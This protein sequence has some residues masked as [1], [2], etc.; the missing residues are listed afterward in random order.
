[1]PKDAFCAIKCTSCVSVPVPRRLLRVFFWSVLTPFLLTR[2]SQTAFTLELTEFKLRYSV[3]S[4]H[5]EHPALAGNTWGDENCSSHFPY[6]SMITPWRHLSHFKT[7][8]LKISLHP[9][10]SFVL[11]I[12]CEQKSLCTKTMDN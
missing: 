6:T 9:S 11:D 12:L 8:K 4:R 7:A 10:S 2:Q 3:P 5:L 1:M